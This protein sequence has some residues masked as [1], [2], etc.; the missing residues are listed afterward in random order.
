MIIMTLVMVSTHFISTIGNSFYLCC[1]VSSD[2][3]LPGW[4]AWCD[5]SSDWLPVHKWQAMIGQCFPR[6]SNSLCPFHTRFTIITILSLILCCLSA[7]EFNY[8][9]IF[10]ITTRLLEF[11]ITNHF[12]FTANEQ[13][14]FSMVGFLTMPKL[15]FP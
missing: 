6:C 10:N 7:C 5:L 14:P 4:K 9:V 12:T 13:I 11:I 15:G 2:Q 1:S 3:I 8:S